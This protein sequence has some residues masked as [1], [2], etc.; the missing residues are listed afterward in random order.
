MDV[1]R[2]SDLFE[3]L[4]VNREK[5]KNSTI[6]VLEKEYEKDGVFTDYADVN[7]GPGWKETISEQVFLLLAIELDSNTIYGSTPSSYIGQVV[8]SLFSDF[9]EKDFLTQEIV[10]TIDKN[11]SSSSGMELGFSIISNNPQTK[12]STPPPEARIPL[13]N[14][15]DAGL[16]YRGVPFS[17]GYSTLED[18]WSNIPYPGVT[19]NNLIPSTL[20]ESVLNGYIGYSSY[21]PLESIY[22]PIGADSINNYDLNSTEPINFTG[23]SSGNSILSEFAKE[24]ERS[25]AIYQ[26]SLIGDTNGYTTF[27]PK[28]MSNGD[29]IDVSLIPDFAEQN[30]DPDKGR[31]GLSRTFSPLF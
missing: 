24:F 26:V 11:N 25:A 18:Y 8:N 16:D 28:T 14:S 17:T 4:V 27:D 13:E 19:G 10:S 31:V 12:V 22:N 1:Q 30:A 15:I 3:S 9:E 21:S 23:S 6:E 2:P 5:F 29:L 7:Y 20:R